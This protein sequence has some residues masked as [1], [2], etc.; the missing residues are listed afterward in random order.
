MVT[1]P[2]LYISFDDTLYLHGF[3]YQKTMS[4]FELMILGTSCQSFNLLFS[5]ALG[6]LAN[7]TSCMTSVV[8]DGI[9]GFRIPFPRRIV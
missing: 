9:L 8:D 2:S 7:M 6:E 3:G 5:H 1:T 4:G